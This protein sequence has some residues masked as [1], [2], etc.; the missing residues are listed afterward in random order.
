M[1]P[2]F[3]RFAMREGAVGF[4]PR[5]ETISAAAAHLVAAVGKAALDG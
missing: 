5:A 4:D 3:H 2:I 1:G